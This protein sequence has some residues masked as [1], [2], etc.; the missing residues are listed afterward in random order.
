MRGFHERDPVPKSFVVL[1]AGTSQE[2]K[3]RNDERTIHGRAGD[4]LPRAN[5]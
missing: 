5:P 2:S 4:N 3:H 1:S